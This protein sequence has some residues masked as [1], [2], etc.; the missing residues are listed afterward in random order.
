MMRTYC[1]VYLKETKNIYFIHLSS[2]NQASYVTLF[3][4]VNFSEWSEQVTFHLGAVD[5]D[6]GLLLDRHTDFTDASSEA[7]KS[8]HKAWTRS[9]R[10]SLN[11]M[12]MTIPNNIK[13]TR[14]GIKNQNAKDFLKLVEE[15]IRYANKALAG[16]LMA[17]LTTMKFDGSKS[18]QQHVFDMTN[19]ATRLKTLGMNVDD[20][21]LMQFIM[22]SL[23]LEYGPF[24]INYNTLNDKWNIDELSSKL[25]QDEERLKKQRVH[26]VNLVNQ[27]VDKSSNPKPRTLKRNNMVQPQ[28]FLM[29]K[30]RNNRTTNAIFTRN[31]DISQRIALSVRLGSKRKGSSKLVPKT[32]FELWTGRKPILRHLHVWSCLAEAQVYN[33]QEKKLDSQTVIGYFIGYPEKSKGYGFIVQTVVL[34]LLKQA[35]PNF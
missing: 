9:K 20:S 30:R 15:K 18:M 33:P 13:S 8:H 17:K 1:Y 6:L 19:I 34:E 3:T 10:L 11:F 35:M 12:R 31:K 24:H 2:I 32:S 25:I 22:N 27:G 7:H 4:V 23:P 29:V 21:F 14:L 26:F 5:I 28:R 16:T